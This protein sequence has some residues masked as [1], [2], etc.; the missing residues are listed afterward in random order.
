[1]ELR[2]ARKRAPSALGF[3]LIIPLPFTLAC[4]RE[5]PLAPSPI[6]VPDAVTIGVG[7]TQ[8]FT[9][10]NATVVGFAVRVDGQRWSEC[11][12][13]DSGLSVRNAIGLVARARCRGLVYVTANIGL[14]RS[15]LLA[16]MRVR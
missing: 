14:D 1:M 12:E 15:P 8:V 10:Q 2:R 4:A 7:D 11:V 13:L 3:V 16:V 9:V 6:I 5:A